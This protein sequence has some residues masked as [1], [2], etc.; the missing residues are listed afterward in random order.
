M[1]ARIPDEFAWLIGSPGNVADSL[2]PAEILN[3]IS[4]LITTIAPNVDTQSLTKVFGLEVLARCFVDTWVTLHNSWGVS[5]KASEFVYRSKT[6]YA[7][8]STIPPPSPALARY[9]VE[10]VQGLQDLEALAQLYID[11]QGHV[12]ETIAP[13]DARR[14]MRVSVQL[15]RIWICREEGA[16]LGYCAIGR[17]TSRTISIRNVYVSPQHR[18]KGVAEAMVRALTR[19]YLGA[20]PLGFDGAPSSGPAEGIKAEICLNVFEEDVERVYKRCGFLI[21]ADDPAS[22]K[23][24]WFYGLS[25]GVVYD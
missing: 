5:V 24:G 14:I 11:F 10:L 18:R 16:I 1:L 15:G 4:L 8:L 6:S 13:E 2:T 17:A 25:A 21:G 22:G 12:L 19:F 7:S 20:H 3:A 23:K 9:R